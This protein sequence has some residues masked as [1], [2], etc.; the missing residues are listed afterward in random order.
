MKTK[1]LSQ[2]TLNNEVMHLACDEAPM[3]F[4]GRQS[5]AEF[6]DRYGSEEQ[7]RAPWLPGTISARLGVSRMRAQTLLPAALRNF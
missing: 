1:N 3:K 4:P 5:L 7:C 6:T 2:V